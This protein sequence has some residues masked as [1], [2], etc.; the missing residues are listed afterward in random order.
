MRLCLIPWIPPPKMVPGDLPCSLLII[1]TL[2]YTLYQ[3]HITKIINTIPSPNNHEIRKKD[4]WP[5]LGLGCKSYPFP[6]FLLPFP[7]SH[8]PSLTI[9]RTRLL[10]KSS[11]AEE[12]L[13]NFQQLL[14]WEQDSLQPCLITSDRDYIL[15]TNSK[16]SE[17]VSWAKCLPDSLPKGWWD[18]MFVAWSS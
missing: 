10:L 6:P 12:R 14:N 9:G 15:T 8:L 17:T 11:L 7:P 18:N 16:D 3:V 2:L 13:R 4:N 1:E 5:G